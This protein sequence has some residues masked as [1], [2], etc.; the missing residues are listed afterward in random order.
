MKSF[1]ISRGQVGAGVA[2]QGAPAIA[3]HST[4]QVD[5]ARLDKVQFEPPAGAPV[6]AGLA[7]SAPTLAQQGELPATSALDV[8][9][10]QKADAPHRRGRTAAL[11]VRDVK[12]EADASTKRAFKPLVELAGP[13]QDALAQFGIKR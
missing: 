7:H 2:P 4:P 3:P 12:T 13:L 10:S 1:E 8:L 6:A 5:R 11:R 9:S